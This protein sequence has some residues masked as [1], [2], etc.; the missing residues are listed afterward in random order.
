MN[1]AK[2]TAILSTVL[3]VPYNW[4]DYETPD[5]P[6]EWHYYSTPDYDTVECPV[7]LVRDALRKGE[8]V[9]IYGRSLH[10]GNNG[11]RYCDYSGKWEHDV[12][13]DYTPFYVPEDRQTCPITFEIGIGMGLA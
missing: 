3:A 13:G 1:L 8:P 2:A 10:V 6:I 12:P 9:C 7:E 11:I 4:V 5:N